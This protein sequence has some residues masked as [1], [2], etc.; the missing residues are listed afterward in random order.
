MKIDRRFSLFALITTTITQQQTTYNINEF[1]PVEKS[2][3]TSVMRAP[4]QQ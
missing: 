4:L 1:T 3:K 2:G